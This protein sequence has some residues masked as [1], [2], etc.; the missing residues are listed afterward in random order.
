M[1]T[2]VLTL[3][4]QRAAD[5]DRTLTF[6]QKI[7]LEF[8]REQHGNGPVHFSCELAGTVIEIYPGKSATAPDRKAGGATMIG[9][10]VANVD[11]LVRALANSSEVIIT[12]PQDSAW[13]RR[14]VIQD[15]DGRAVELSTRA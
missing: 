6:Y 1:L 5:L 13:G 7:G 4:V 12:A 11:E 15:P 9:F 2:P 8:A 10:Q 14:A 3:L